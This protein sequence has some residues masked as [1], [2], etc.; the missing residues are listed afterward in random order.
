MSFFRMDIRF[1]SDISFTKSMASVDDPNDQT[2]SAFQLKFLTFDFRKGQKILDNLGQ[3][4]VCLLI[5]CTN[6]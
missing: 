6:W 5:T 4:V 1:L 2:F 3:P